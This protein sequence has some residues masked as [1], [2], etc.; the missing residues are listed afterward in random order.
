MATFT[1][2]SCATLEKVTR[3]LSGHLR[4]LQ[5]LRRLVH[6]LAADAS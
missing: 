5:H 1:G 6:A 3:V 2:I 4:R